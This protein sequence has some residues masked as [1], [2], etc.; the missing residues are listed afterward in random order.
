MGFP[1]YYRRTRNTQARATLGSFHRPVR[2][3]SPQ[4]LRRQ[5]AKTAEPRFRLPRSLRS[6]R[7][8]RDRPAS[9]VDTVATGIIAEAVLVLEG[10]VMLHAAMARVHSLRLLVGRLQPGPFARIVAGTGLR[11]TGDV[12]TAVG[13]E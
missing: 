11:V 5:A 7:V 9:R 8:R 3:V 12:R 6:S 10:G 4:R 13:V 1:Y 2:F